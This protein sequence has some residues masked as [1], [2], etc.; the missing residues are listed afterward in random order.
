M[1]SQGLFKIK[2]KGGKKLAQKKNSG[3]KKGY[4]KKKKAL[5]EIPFFTRPN[6]GEGNPFGPIVQALNSFLII[7]KED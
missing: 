2:K 3:K 1:A 4:F 7:K 5:P 6:L